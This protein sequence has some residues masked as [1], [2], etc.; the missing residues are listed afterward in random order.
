MFWTHLHAQIHRT[1]RQRQLLP[2]KERVLIAVSGGQDSL[3]LAQLL[4]DL[5][6]KWGWEIAIAHCDHR[7]RADSSANAEHV[8]QLA[9]SWQLPFYLQTAT[10]PPVS[11]ASARQW[12]YQALSDIALKYSYKYIVTGHTA[13]DRAET[14]LYNLMRGSGADGLQALT[15]KRLLMVEG[16]YVSHLYIVRPLL[17]IVRAQ[18]GEFCEKIGLKVWEDSTNADIKY[19]RNR[20]RRELIPYLQANFNPQ[21][22][23]HLAQTAE[24]LR[25]DVEYLEE[26]ARH[27]LEKSLSQNSVEVNNLSKNI[28]INRRTLQDAPLAIQRR[29]IRQLLQKILTRAPNFEQ[30]EKLTAMISA[31]NRYQTDPFPGGALARVEGDWICIQIQ[32]QL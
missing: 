5:Q 7:W 32:G 22:E 16:E 25:A 12:R 1:L 29:A 4:R 21:V 8:R 31:P 26:S 19:T 9:N 13:S 6:P 11:E 2:S 20:I 27:L 15:W 14:L 24:L 3:C 10:E 30:V 23:Q 28:R 18:T 17:E